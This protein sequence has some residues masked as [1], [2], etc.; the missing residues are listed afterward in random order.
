MDVVKNYHREQFGCDVT[1]VKYDLLKQV[2]HVY[3][4]AGNCT[5]MDS[6]I[7]FFENQVPEISHIITWCDGE[8]DTQYVDHAGDG[9]WIAI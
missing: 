8:I 6:T 4:P 3:M 7:K 9:S 2:G 1:E 5:D